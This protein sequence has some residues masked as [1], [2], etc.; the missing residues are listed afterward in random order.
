MKIDEFLYPADFVILDMEVDQ[1]Y[2]VLLGRAFMKTSKMVVDM[3]QGLLQIK[4]KKG[5]TE[6]LRI[7]DV[8]KKGRGRSNM[9]EEF[10]QE[11]H[12]PN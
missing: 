1:E 7:Y 9:E 5:G 12:D 6:K 10:M 2:P 3:E 11:G 4:F 8:F